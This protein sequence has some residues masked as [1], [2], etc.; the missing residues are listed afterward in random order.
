VPISD[1]GEI[2]LADIYGPIRLAT[3]RRGLKKAEKPAATISKVVRSSSRMAP[4]HRRALG[5]YGLDRGNAAREAV[6]RF[7]IKTRAH[8][9]RLQ[10]IARCARMNVRIAKL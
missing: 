2:Q 6:L 9:R 8:V 5:L 3:G 7:R 4:A 1:G 10:T